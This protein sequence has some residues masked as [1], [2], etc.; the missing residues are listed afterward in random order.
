VTLDEAAAKILE[1]MGATPSG[2]RMSDA[3]AMDAALRE[4]GHIIQD[5]KITSKTAE[6]MR[7][8][9]ALGKIGG[10]AA[11]ERDGETRVWLVT[12]SGIFM[13][14][15]GPVQYTDAKPVVPICSEVRTIIDDATG[16]SLLLIYRPADSCS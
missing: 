15:G 4:A 5:G 3:S 14:P 12:V 16:E 10:P 6:A 7:W 8:D 2:M 13:P 9:A 1:A 11:V